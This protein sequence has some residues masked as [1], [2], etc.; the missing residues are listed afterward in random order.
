[1]EQWFFEFQVEPTQDM[2][3]FIVV[4]ET[5][6]AQLNEMGEP[7]TE[8]VVISKKLCN[9]PMDYRHVIFAWENILEAI[10]TL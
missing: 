9:L 3:S 7:T 10:K 2:F 6:A 5:M 8:N 1:M 4:V